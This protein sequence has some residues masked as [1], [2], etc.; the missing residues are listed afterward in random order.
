MIYSIQ[1]KGENSLLSMN[2]TQSTS[3]CLHKLSK[4]CTN[5]DIVYCK[6]LF[7]TNLVTN[8]SGNNFYF[9]NI[10]VACLNFSKKTVSLAIMSESIKIDLLSAGKSM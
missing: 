1:L 8:K 5:N 2:I 3:R 9:Q 10:H 6:K 7:K 4:A